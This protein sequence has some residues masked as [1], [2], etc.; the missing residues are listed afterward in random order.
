V[1][2]KSARKLYAYLPAPRKESSQPA[3]IL[4]VSGIRSVRT[5][6]TRVLRRAGYSV[7]EAADCTEAIEAG[8]ERQPDIIVMNGFSGSEEIKL[9]AKLRANPTMREVPL[10]S[11]YSSRG[12]RDAHYADSCFLE[13]VKPTTLISIVELVLR[14]RAAERRLVQGVAASNHG[15][16]TTRDTRAHD[17]LSPLCT[18]SSLAAWIRGEYADRLGGGGREYLG[19][20]EQSVERMREVIARTFEPPVHHGRVDCQLEVPITGQPSTARIP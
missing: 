9:C 12:R 7:I 20:L 1:N 3:I 10:I 16:T 18:I 13:P 5:L 4:N 19:M 17:L 2:V 8:A 15:S 14:V 6:R 11:L